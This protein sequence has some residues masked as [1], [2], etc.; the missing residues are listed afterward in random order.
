MLVDQTLM[1]G[2]WYGGFMTFQPIQAEDTS[3]PREYLVRVAVGE[4]IHVFR[5]TATS[6]RP[7]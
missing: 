1:P 7:S 3:K 6:T 4:D 2:E 5:T